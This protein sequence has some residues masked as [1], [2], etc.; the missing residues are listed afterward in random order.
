MNKKIKPKQGTVVRIK[1]DP[2]VSALK[3]FVTMTNG[4]PSFFKLSPEE[5][6]KVA[7]EYIQKQKKSLGEE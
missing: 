7:M 2:Y 3:E 1:K 6:K 5:Q 4:D